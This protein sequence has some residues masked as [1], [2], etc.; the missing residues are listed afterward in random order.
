MQDLQNHRTAF[1]LHVTEVKR[2]GEAAAAASDHDRPTN[3]YD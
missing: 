2:R 1:Y 3:Q